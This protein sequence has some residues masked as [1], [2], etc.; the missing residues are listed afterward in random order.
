MPTA[1]IYYL[2]SQTQTGLPNAYWKLIDAYGSI[3]TSGSLGTDRG[4]VPLRAGP[5]TVVIDGY[6]AEDGSGSY[7]FNVV[8]V[9]DGTQAL[10]LG[11]VAG[12]AI[13]VPGQVQ[14][15]TF[16]LGNPAR[17]YFDARTNTGGMRWSLS[18]PGA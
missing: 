2:N 9:T 1:G 5:Y 10:T 16:S 17:L 11:E 7:S 3:V 6:Y 14:R 13:A 4:R 15:Y 8:P 12:G 18:G